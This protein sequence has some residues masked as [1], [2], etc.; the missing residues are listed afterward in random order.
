MAAPSERHSRANW[1]LPVILLVLGLAVTSAAVHQTRH[2]VERERQAEVD[3]AVDRLRTDLALH[4]YRHL[5]V[6]RTYQAEFAA[7]PSS[8]RQARERMTRI[9]KV[10]ERLPGIDSLGYVTVTPGSVD[11]EVF[12]I[13]HLYPEALAD[14]AYSS[15]IKDHPVRGDAMN[16]ARDSGDFAATAPV[17]SSRANAG[18]D[19]IMVYLPLYRDGLTP[20]DPVERRRLFVGTVFAAL[21]PDLLM[22]SLFEQTHPLDA[23]VKLL[24][25]GYAGAPAGEFPPITLHDAARETQSP[26]STGLVRRTLD[27][28]GTTWSLEVAMPAA[29]GAES[30][31]WLPWTVMAVGLLMSVLSAV[32]VGALQRSRQR[33]LLRATADRDRRVVA[34][35]AL[36]LRQRAIEASANA[37]VI[38]SATRPGYPVEYV[39]P[40]FERMT[41]YSASEI[42]GQSLRIM[43]GG[44]T[45]QDGLEA[46]K[47]ILQERREGQ[48]TLRNYRKDGQLYWTRVH[49]APVRDDAGEVTHFVA[50]KYDITEMRQYQEKLEFRAWH[51]ALTGLPN[52]HMLRER[53]QEAIRN[54][55]DGDPPFWVAFLDLD[56]FKLINDTVGH[57]QGDVVLQQIAGRLQQALHPGDIVARRGGDEFVF[58]LF[59]R[60]PPRNAL[61]TLHRI[62]SAVSRPLKQESHRF[63]PSCSIGV[64][65]Y[66]QDGDDPE[67]LI[68]HADMAMYHAKE[69]GRKNY[70]F[71]STAL[72]EQ[73]MKRVTL[74]GDLRAALVNDEFELH[75]Q[76]QVRLF[77]R[78]LTG[79]E[80]LVRWRHPERGLIPPDQFI[81]IAEETGLIVPLGEWILR[82]ACRQAAQWRDKGISGLRMAVN[83]SARQFNDQQLPVLI[84][85]ILDEYGLPPE[86]LELELTETLLMDDVE[87]ANAILHKLKGLGITL[88]LDDFGTGYSSLAQLKRYPL[89]ILKIDRSFVTDIA[90]SL[91]GDAIIRAII[92]LAHNMGMTA[93]AEGVE[94]REQAAFL[95]EHGCDAIQGYLVGKPMPPKDFWSWMQAYAP[96]EAGHAL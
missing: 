10:E 68:K 74:E 62:M 33:S 46:L 66:P 83:L 3:A 27:V 63:Y 15:G 55:R 17:S 14:L 95:Q 21:R 31:R 84:H 73:A 71:Y 13:Q 78:R 29:D 5:D 61:A 48:T 58:I 91:G 51:D 37:I 59:D 79:M 6:L 67:I 7:H 4:I 94:T 25:R 56:Q 76:P 57:T 72:H 19:V 82:T 20:A 89:D 41:G 40:A 34:E 43:H 2:F 90:P 24:F 77:D 87:S 16:R 47:R 85:C 12:D 70:Q 18:H 9:M 45:R 60:D 35:A 69:Q 53:L 8:S 11:H 54:T 64:A 23:H 32:M 42:Q 36:H 38:S 50:A 49:I 80:A 28:A 26:P 75:Y 22:T 92:Q 39:N 52:R 88:S 1:W 30:Q 65:I 81:P 86:Q 96:Q 44:D 93:I